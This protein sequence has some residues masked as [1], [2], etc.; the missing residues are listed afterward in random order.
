[1]EA[2]EPEGAPPL[3]PEGRREITTSLYLL[4]V[5]CWESIT[6][7]KSAGAD[8]WSYPYVWAVKRGQ[9]LGQ[10][11]TYSRFNQS[12]LNT[13]R[14][15]KGRLIKRGFKGSYLS[16]S[17]KESLIRACKVCFYQR[18]NYNSDLGYLM[19]FQGSGIRWL[20]KLLRENLTGWFWNS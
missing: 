13:L 15:W 17:F 19:E 11:P 20:V 4:D 5:R 14:S 8:F 2:P 16:V 6:I 12:T 3:V 18:S 1:M 9:L 10:S 7:F